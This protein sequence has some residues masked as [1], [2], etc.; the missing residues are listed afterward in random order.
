MEEWSKERT[1]QAILEAVENGGDDEI[2][3]VLHAISQND[4]FV[5][6]RLFGLG[7]FR[8]MELCGVQ[9]NSE[10]C[11]KWASALHISS[12]KLEQ[13]WDIYQ[14]SL[15]RL[16]Q[17]EQLFAELEARQ[18]KKLADKLAERAKRAQEEAAKAEQEQV[19]KPNS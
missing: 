10:R 4:W 19:T 15:E 6:S 16:K 3:K 2:S 13:D 12:L 1:E 8:M 9:V 5:Y 7:L 18:K 17:A 14:Q 11:Q